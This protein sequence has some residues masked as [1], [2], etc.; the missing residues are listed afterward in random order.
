MDNGININLNPNINYFFQSV[1]LKD[2]SQTMF[3]KHLV[4]RWKD[5]V[6]FP[7]RM[8]TE[9]PFLLANVEP[10]NQP[11]LDAA[12]GLG[13]ESIFLAKN[14]FQVVANEI[15]PSFAFKAKSLASALGLKIKF[16]AID[17]TNLKE[18]FRGQKFG[19]VLLLGN[20]FCLIKDR[21][22]QQQIADNLRRVC[23]KGGRLIIDRRNFEYILDKREEI[24]NGDFRYQGRVM[25]CGKS[26]IGVPENISFDNIRFIYRDAETCEMLGHLD[27]SPFLDEE[28]TDIFR[29]NGFDLVQ[30]YSDLEAG[31]KND[32]DFY[33]YIF[34]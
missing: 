19:T 17:W 26:V 34:Q 23:E 8:K 21:H 5:F 28:F 22:Q 33:T 32:A 9:G 30:K 13:Y 16:T 20:S 2:V 3:K 10:N 12:A 14:G 24:L 29:Q 4:E 7:L 15:D 6:D 1:G 11:V 18:K 31:N 25:Y 27:M